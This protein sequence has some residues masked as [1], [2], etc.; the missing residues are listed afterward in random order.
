MRI[1]K[2]I[3]NS[4]ANIL[5]L[6]L[7][8]IPNLIIRKVFLD[9]LGSES[10]GLLSLYSNI[11]GW[12]SVLELGIGSAIIFSLYKPYA[13]NDFESLKSY[14]KYYGI[15]YRKTGL[16]IIISSVLISPFMHFFIEGNMNNTLIST[17][18]IL[19]S[20]NTFISYMFSHKL[21]ILNV[22]QESYIVTLTSTL[23]KLIIS[24]LQFIMLKLYPNFY[25]YIII[26]IIINLIYYIGI[27]IYIS[28]RF[29]WI[30]DNCKDIDNDE[31]DKLFKNMKS[32]FMHR[33]GG[34]VLLSTDNI[35]IS[36]F[37]GLITLSKYTNYFTVLNAIQSVVT[38]I[39]NGITASVGNLVAEG[40][41]EKSY[42]IHKNLFFMIFWIT[43]FIT[44]SLYNT[45]DQ[46]IVM[47]V[48]K[49]N[50]IDNTTICIIL[51]NIYLTCLREATDQFKYAAGLFYQDR[52]APIFEAIINL[53]VSLV[54]VN[55]IG[56]AGV[57]IGTFISNILVVFWIKPYIVYK[58]VF[59]I[60]IIEYFKMY[61]K[62]VLIGII[63]LFVTSYVT[64]YFKY[65]Y[66]ITSFIINCILNI[67]IINS[68]YII[69]F[70][71]S[72]EFKYFISIVKKILKRKH[73]MKI[74]I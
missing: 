3:I 38:S 4:S 2:S 44:I 42:E 73:K 6:I 39:V 68:I 54:L 72:K 10:L 27:N 25:I 34:L 59:N 65:K 19:F 52:Y 33:V 62:Y 16:I 43:S 40:N 49:N 51:I 74:K 9:S 50:L 71:K 29:K 26:Q 5:S 60:N 20:I 30:N 37:L 35:I 32:L 23:S 14:I 18:F 11:M 47:W 70:Y 28:R 1:Q 69:I 8:F 55:K 63:P 15:F 12:M 48:G 53:V 36:K 22:S 57:F 56:L 13:N 64:S 45:I 24:I 21:C 58:Y 31:K 46:F 61:F 41:K 67:V 17:G 66:G 7:S